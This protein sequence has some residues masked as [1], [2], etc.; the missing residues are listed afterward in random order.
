M[1]FVE[2]QGDYTKVKELI[3]KNEHPVGVSRITI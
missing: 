3:F 2:N 1:D